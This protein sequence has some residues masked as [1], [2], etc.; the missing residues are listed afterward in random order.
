M[1]VVRTPEGVFPDPTGKAPGRGAYLHEQRS[2]WEA[3]LKQGSLSRALRVDLTS[4]DT[5]RLT[6]TLNDLPEETISE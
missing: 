3:A 1:R 4:E 5:A 6:A 2:C